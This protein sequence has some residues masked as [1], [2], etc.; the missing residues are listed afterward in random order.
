MRGENLTVQTPDFDHLANDIGH[1]TSRNEL[2]FKLKRECMERGFR[3][4][5]S[6]GTTNES[7]SLHVIFLCNK[8]GSSIRSKNASVRDLCPFLALYERRSLIGA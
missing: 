7:K 1:I 6:M 4:K 8:R 3:S 2:V 5:L